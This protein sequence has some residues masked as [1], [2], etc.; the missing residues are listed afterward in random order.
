MVS[1]D[2]L[3]ASIVRICFYLMLEPTSHIMILPV[4]EPN[5]N[6]LSLIDTF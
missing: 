4:T 6:F 1:D 2:K 3:T 5:F